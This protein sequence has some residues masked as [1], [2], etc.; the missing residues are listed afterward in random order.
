MVVTNP[1]VLDN[2][3]VEGEDRVALAQRAEQMTSGLRSRN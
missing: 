2:A 3:I 1:A